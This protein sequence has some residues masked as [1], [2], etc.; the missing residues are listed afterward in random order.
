[1][2]TMLGQSSTWNVD[3]PIPLSDVGSVIAQAGA[4]VLALAFGIGIGFM[5]VKKLKARLTRAV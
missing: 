2:F 5:L 1:M 3:F 4:A